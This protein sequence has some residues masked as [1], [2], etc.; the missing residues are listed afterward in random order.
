MKK[1][2]LKKRNVTPTS[3]NMTFAAANAAKSAV[4]TNFERNPKEKHAAVVS[5]FF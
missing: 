4:A 5:L 2:E 3:P 1:K